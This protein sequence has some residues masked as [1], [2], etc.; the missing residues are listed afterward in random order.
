V[1]KALMR[2]ALSAALCAK[3]P[4]YAHVLLNLCP[5]GTFKG[6]PPTFT[7]ARYLTKSLNPGDLPEIAKTTKIDAGTLAEVV[8][9]NEL[10]RPLKE[11]LVKLLSQ[12]LATALSDGLDVTEWAAAITRVSEATACA[13]TNPLRG[14]LFIS[15]ADILEEVVVIRP[16]LG[17]VIERDCTGQIFG[18][19]GSGKSFV[20]LDMAMSVGTGGE[21]NGN[22]CGK[23][24]VIY[25]AGEGHSGL[26]RRI[27]AWNKRNPGKDLSNVHIS[28]TAISFTTEGLRTAVA[29]ITELEE[30]TGQL[31]ALVIVDTLA[32]HIEGD[33]NSTR[34]MGG[35][36]RA[37]DG[38]RCGFPGSSAIVVHHT[39]ND[40]EKSNRSRGSS[41]LKGACDFEIQ[42][43]KGLLTYMK[44]KDGELPVS[45]EFKLVPIEIGRDADDEPIT[46]CIVFYGERSVK[47]QEVTLTT[48]ERMIVNL[49][50]R[51]PG[52]LTGD[53][54]S[55]YYDERRKL[56]PEATTN[57]LKNSFLRSFQKL[58]EKQ[59]ITEKD[60]IVSVKSDASSSVTYPSPAVTSDAP[61][62]VTYRH[63]P[64][65][66]SDA[67]DA[68]EVE[69]VM[70]LH[71]AD[72]FM[73]AQA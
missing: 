15:A 48:Y 60:N 5:E 37:V 14:P 29:E 46:S 62:P 4:A 67:G 36:V 41:A 2:D 63:S 32:R 31:V 3:D 50:K 17:K 57:T 61:S 69:T 68:L 24:A 34:D 6:D 64:T 25:F 51:T 8:A 28:S 73:G 12:R 52:I 66:R 20:A 13:D 9:A 10:M 35:F 59:A 19:S 30:A 40:A 33:E 23:G 47:H 71:E 38:L 27:K 42:C 45:V 11:H 72:L 56:D 49:A 44:V 53:L 65:G 26:K 70:T 54:R 43:D 1:I 55:N 22:K 18:P 21:W 16:L 58:V 7:L 39:G